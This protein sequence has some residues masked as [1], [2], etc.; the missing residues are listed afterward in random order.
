MKRKI[1]NGL[2][3]QDRSPGLREKQEEQAL[4]KAV[5]KRGGI[6][7]K[8]VSPA[9]D[10]MPDRLLLMPG[11]N[12][13]FVE[14]KAPGKKPRPLQVSRHGLL[15]RLGFKVYVLDSPADIAGMLDEIGGN[16]R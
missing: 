8:F 4:V 5:R 7:L 10:G 3:K 6:A 14:V 16:A 9:F 13:G 1:Q 12:I 11:G 15:R 2:D